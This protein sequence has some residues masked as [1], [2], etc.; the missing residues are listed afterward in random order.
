MAHPAD[1]HVTVEQHIEHVRELL[2]DIRPG[3]ETVSLAAALGRVTVDAVLSPVDLPLFRNSQMDGFAVRAAD[4]TTTPTELPI[5]GEIAARPLTPAPLS[6]GTAV[7]IMTG[8]VVPDGADAVVPVEDTT[9]V[10]DR[11][12]ITRSRR[13]GEYV[14]ERGS[15]LVAGTTLLPAGTLLAS[16]HLGALAAAGIG[17]V[18]VRTRVRV[19][20]ITTGSELV[21]VDSEPTLGQVFD[22]NA[23]AVQAA[24]LAAGAAVTFTARV[25]DDV[26]AMT[27]A[28][29]LAAASSDIIVTSGGISMG[30]YEVVR[31]A[32]EPLGAVVGHVAMQPGGP[33]ATAVVNGIPVLCFPGNPVSTQLSVEVFLAPLLREWAGHPPAA[34]ER[35]VLSGTIVSVLAKRQFLRGRRLES[36]RVETVSGPGSHLV[37]GLAASDVL[38]DVPLETTR[39]EEGSTVDT[40][41][42]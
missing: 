12:T 39:I 31:E 21:G 18:T 5:V 42:L 30:D 24:V 16:R 19:A 28:L 23:V 34:R 1:F 9:T 3:S 33:Q 4:L 11:V 41:T 17:S 27:E 29:H 2:S 13:L 10:G 8:A 14:R 22:A 40:W 15:D 25:T 6:P 20:V 7:R 35:R 38:I 37:A 36:G 26:T 32:L